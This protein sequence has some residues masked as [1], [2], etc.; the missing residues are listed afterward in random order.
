MK[1][2]LILM[3]AVGASLFSL[4]S[5]ASAADVSIREYSDHYVVDID[6][7]KDA[8]SLPTHTNSAVVPA[9]RPEVAVQSSASQ[10]VAATATDASDKPEPVA[11]AVPVN[12]RMAQ[13]EGYQARLQA[14][15]SDLIAARLAARQARWA[16]YR[17]TPNL[18]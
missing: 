18:Q 15:Q 7:S 4:V 3:A 1:R 13:T 2:F 16:K 12:N 5:L 10:A 14:R 11:A 8:P 6:G 9:K 17:K